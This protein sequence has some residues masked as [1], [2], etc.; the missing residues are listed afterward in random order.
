LK[1]EGYFE[2]SYGH[3]AY[4]LTELFLLHII[5]FYLMMKTEWIALGLIIFSIGNGR[6]GWLMHEGG[7][8]S[9][10]G[11][12]KVDKLLQALLFGLA[13]GMSGS[14]W[15][16]QHNKHHACPQKLEHDVDLNTLPLVAFNQQIAK[17]ATGLN[18]IWLRFQAFLFAPVVVTLVV[19]FWVFFLHP[20]WIIRRK[21]YL[22]GV[23]VTLRALFVIKF[24]SPTIFLANTCV[25]A[26]Y[27]FINFALSHTH[28]AAVPSDEF[29]NWV[30]YAS[31]HTINIQQSWW[32]DWWMGYLNF[33]IEHHLFPTMPQYRQKQISPRVKALFEKHG[34]K[35]EVR[36][37]WQA[38]WDTAK[39][40]HTVGW[41][42]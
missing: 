15:N 33:Q 21:M 25:G 41:E 19:L 26:M 27:I 22:E 14:Y 32:C 29:P 2:P 16:N 3:I 8:G 1:K 42:A 38:L 36:S 23:C 35:Y 11:N 28:T 9:L 24:F 39:N 20:R 10:T 31:N 6:C 7:H 18:R 12:L 40:L 37:Y 4:R 5:G 17:K 13:N 30:S 34:L